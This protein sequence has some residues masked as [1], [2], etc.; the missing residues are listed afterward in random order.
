MTCELKYNFIQENKSK[1]V[2]YILT[3]IVSRPQC[4]NT[5]NLEQSETKLSTCFMRNTTW[6]EMSRAPERALD[7]IKWDISTRLQAKTSWEILVTSGGFDTL[8]LYKMAAILQT[9]FS[10][11]FKKLKKNFV[12]W[13]KFTLFE[14]NSSYLILHIRHSML[15][16]ARQSL[17]HNL[18]Y[19]AYDKNANV[20]VSWWN[21]KRPLII[22]P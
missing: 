21:I 13:L 3:A 15:C 16:I 11:T 1:T 2:V 8:G 12:F 19:L 9:T 7:G 20:Q 14:I 18:T 5:T 22:K 6:L 17:T 4:A 10:Y